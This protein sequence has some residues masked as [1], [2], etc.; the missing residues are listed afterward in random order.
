MRPLFPSGFSQRTQGYWHL[1]LLFSIGAGF[2]A[3]C[4]RYDPR[5]LANPGDCYSAEI[6][7][8]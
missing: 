5:E 4:C 6:S 3:Q 7:V 2:M 8:I 1:Y